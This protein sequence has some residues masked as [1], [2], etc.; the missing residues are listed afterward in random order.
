MIED[1]LRKNEERLRQQNFITLSLPLDL[2]GLGHQ[3]RP[4]LDCSPWR[5]ETFLALA[6][7]RVGGGGS[8]LALALS[9]ICRRSTVA[10]GLTSV[11]L[12]RTATLLL[13]L[14]LGCQCCLIFLFDNCPFLLYGKVVGGLLFR[15]ARYN[16]IRHGGGW[17]GGSVGWLVVEPVVRCVEA[18]GH[19]IE[20]VLLSEGF[21]DGMGCGW[22]YYRLLCVKERTMR[23]LK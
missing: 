3:G 10:I 15:I 18:G 13:L 20:V 1:L 8:L 9:L 6:R 12:R 23:Y 14:L 21:W 5:A 16:Q 2:A 7:R 17:R 11:V 4:R 19:L 22:V